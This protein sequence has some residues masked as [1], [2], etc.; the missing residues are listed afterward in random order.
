VDQQ[1]KDGG[2]PKGQADRRGRIAAPSPADVV[3]VKAMRLEHCDV[4]TQHIH[5]AHNGLSR[6]LNKIGLGKLP[7]DF[8]FC[9]AR[10]S[11]TSH[12]PVSWC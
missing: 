9:W 4:N 3:S 10:G 6:W 12:W 2:M 5:R 11:G 7:G 8:S 1:I